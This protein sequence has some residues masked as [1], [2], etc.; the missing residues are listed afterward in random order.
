MLSSSIRGR[1]GRLW[2]LRGATDLVE[3][4]TIVGSGGMSVFVDASPLGLLV[5]S[6][7]MAAIS[8]AVLT[9]CVE[10]EDLGSAKIWASVFGTTSLVA[11][12]S[13]GRLV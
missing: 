13:F 7:G 4:S 6:S 11:A 8:G 1:G 9:K 10:E 5:A 12:W 2:D 3:P